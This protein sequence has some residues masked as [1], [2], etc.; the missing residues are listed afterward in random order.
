MLVTFYKSFVS[1]IL[2]FL[3]LFS[4][5]FPIGIST[6]FAPV[7]GENVKLT[8]AAVSDTHMTDSEARLFLLKL[9]LSDMENA[10]RPLDAFVHTGDI[11]DHGYERQW[12]MLRKGFDVHTPAKNII[13]AEGNHD[14]WTGEKPDRFSPSKELFIRFNKEISDR[15]IDNVYYSTEINGYTF[16]VLG[17]EDDG[18][19]AYISEAQFAWFEN[20]IEKASESGLPVF[21]VFHQPLNL[22]HGL[23]GTWGEDDATDISGG[24]GDQSDRFNAILQKYKNVFYLS[25]HIHNGVANED[26][27]SL[28]G[29]SSVETHGN[30]TS[31]NLPSYSNVTFRGEMTNGL[32]FVVEVYDDEVIIRTRSFSNGIWYSQYTYTIPLA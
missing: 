1:A 24:I 11:T 5:I 7:D 10:S 21:I 23:P 29:Y 19:D 4:S 18:V 8:F 6:A 16:I 30:V 32:G 15:E 17:S 2:S 25:G 12:L 31:V 28:Y 9:G 20:E 13:L 3:S 26:T 27:S 22:T 14:T